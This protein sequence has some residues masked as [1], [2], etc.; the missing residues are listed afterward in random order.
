MRNYTL[1]PSNKGS[2]GGFI[3]LVHIRDI[4]LLGLIDEFSLTLLFKN[5]V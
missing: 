2:I 5:K 4:Q 3:I 1:F